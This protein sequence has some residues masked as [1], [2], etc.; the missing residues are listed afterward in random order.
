[1]GNRS[2]PNFEIHPS[3]VIA[4]VNALVLRESMKEKRPL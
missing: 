4:E 3:V 1:M 2:Q